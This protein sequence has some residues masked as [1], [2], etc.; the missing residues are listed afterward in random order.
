MNQKHKIWLWGA[1]TIALLLL[2]SYSY[3]TAK[4][5]EAQS[6]AATK[7]ILAHYTTEACGGVNGTVT[8]FQINDETVTWTLDCGKNGNKTA[9][10]PLR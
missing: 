8:S 3:L 10:T 9:T 4:D 7:A 2:A 6:V 5:A 1:I